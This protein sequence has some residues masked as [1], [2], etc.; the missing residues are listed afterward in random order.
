MIVWEKLHL[1]GDNGKG[2]IGSEFLFDLPFPSHH[3]LS[4]LKEKGKLLY[5]R[6]KLFCFKLHFHSMVRWSLVFVQ[7]CCIWTQST[8]QGLEF[9]SCLSPDIIVLICVQSATSPPCMTCNLRLTRTLSESYWLS[10]VT[11]YVALSMP[12]CSGE[13]S[14]VKSIFAVLWSHSE[15]K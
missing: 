1:V 4:D 11:A 5:I 2:Y 6:R 12:F 8:N 10:C 7:A 15:V 9:S 3:S 13:A 14:C